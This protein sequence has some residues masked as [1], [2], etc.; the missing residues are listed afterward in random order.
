MDGFDCLDAPQTTETCKSDRG[1]LG[2]TD[3]HLGLLLLGY[4]RS[5]TSEQP[6]ISLIQL[7]FTNHTN[8]LGIH[9]LIAVPDTFLPRVRGRWRSSV[10]HDPRDYLRKRGLD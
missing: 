2:R 7:L 3:W 1:N 6:S 10:L 4:S 8:A 5:D 9:K